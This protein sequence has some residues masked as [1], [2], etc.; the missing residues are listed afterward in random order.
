MCVCEN[1][2]IL[3]DLE[4]VVH[5][6]ALHEYPNNWKSA[7]VKIGENLMKQDEQLLYG[8]LCSLKG[9]VKKFKHT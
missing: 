8:T 9:I 3:H 7:L 4:S 5:T 2:V 6:I 1:L